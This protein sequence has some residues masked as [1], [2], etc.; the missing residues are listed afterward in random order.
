MFMFQAP[1]ENGNGVSEHSEPEQTPTKRPLE[2]APETE[3]SECKRVRGDE[4]EQPELPAAPAPNGTEQSAPAPASAEQLS[5]A[6]AA[7]GV[8]EAPNGVNN[9]P[10]PITSGGD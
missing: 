2:A 5:A 9:T 1:V 8:S 10:H 7:A 3:E 6:A 4:T